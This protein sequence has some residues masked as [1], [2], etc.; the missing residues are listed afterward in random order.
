MKAIAVIGIG[1][2]IAGDD[3]A[4]VEVVLRLK[5]T[6]EGN[7]AV[8]LHVL[9][10]DH[11]EIAGLLDQAERFI[12]VDAF[13]GETP[14]EIVRAAKLRRAFAPSFHQTDIAS[15]MACLETLRVVDPFPEWEIRGVTIIPPKII[16]E[17]LT[18]EVEAAVDVLVEEISRIIQE[19]K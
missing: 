13:E 1:N 6:W 4:G 10:G 12:F 11:F 16:G 2:T 18:P 14:G 5:K 17:G 15:V 7:P 9:E 3:G 8:F 19:I